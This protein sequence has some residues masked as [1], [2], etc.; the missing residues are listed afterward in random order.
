MGMSK[1][2]RLEDDAIEKCVG[3]CNTMLEQVRDA[4]KEADRLR[5]VTGFG[6]FASAQE[7]QAGYQSKFTGEAGSVHQ[8]LIQFRDAII[9][10]RDTFAA[11]GE[12]FANADSAIRQALGAIQEDTPA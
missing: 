10:M 3:V 9:L 5:M 1:T 2:L 11:G 8:R 7:L 6:G 12:A 4:I